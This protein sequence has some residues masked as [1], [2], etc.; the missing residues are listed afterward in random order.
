[1]DDAGRSYDLVGPAVGQPAG[2]RAAALGPDDTAYDVLEFA[3]PSGPFRH[4]DL[5]LPASNVGARGAPITV[6]IPMA[7]VKR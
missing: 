2:A 1:V 7:L 6:R 5:E 4:F 3:G